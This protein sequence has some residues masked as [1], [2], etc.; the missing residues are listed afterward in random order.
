MNIKSLSFPILYGTLILTGSGCSSD[1]PEKIHSVS[2]TGTQ[3][4]LKVNAIAKAADG[5]F[6]SYPENGKTG[7]QHT[8]DARIYIFE[9]LGNNALYSGH[10]FNAHWSE[11][12]T[13]QGKEVPIH[14]DSII[15]TIP[16]LF[17]EGQEYTFVGISQSKEAVNVFSNPIDF[18]QASQ[19]QSLT[20]GMQPGTRLE[21]LA[22]SEIYTG[23]IS[24]TYTK[25][26]KPELELY[27][28]VAGV[29]G[30]F[31]NIPRS[32]KDH[33]QEVKKVDHIDINLYS[34]QNT[35]AWIFKHEQ[36]PVFGDY[37]QSPSAEEK[38][39][40]IATIDCNYDRISGMT[41][42]TIVQGGSYL[43]P[44]AAPSECNYTLRIDL[45]AEDGTTLKSIRAKLPK[46]DGLD[47][48]STGGGTGIIDNESAFRYPI[49][50]NHFYSIGNADKPIDLKGTGTELTIYVDSSW[51]DE[52]D[53]E[54]TD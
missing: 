51:K 13:K 39:N 33:S 45:M 16:Y 23:S 21:Q 17:H 49:V 18:A 26:C 52:P 28:R 35:Q 14:T 32:L 12:F 46:D 42:Q 15:C 36:T 11:Y 1:K 8:T 44:A 38:P 48:G 22:R 31:T 34:P 27:R 25:N 53:L 24:F 10:S 29:M 37:I 20:F 4:T 6:I 40:T 2:P 3:I 54:V 5:S 19:I 41:N 50:A 30:Y 9:G 7:T 43:L 47:H